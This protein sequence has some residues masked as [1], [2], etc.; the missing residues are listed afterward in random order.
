M[1][2]ENHWGLTTS[3]DT[4]LAIHKAVGSPWLGI[5]MDTGNYPGDP[6]AGIATLAPH[7]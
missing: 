6:Y 3:V 7:G 5:N 1:A 2:L 4:L